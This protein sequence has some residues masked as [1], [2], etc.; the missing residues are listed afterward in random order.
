MG[1]YRGIRRLFP[2]ICCSINIYKKKTGSG[3]NDREEED[4]NFSETYGF[5][6]VYVARIF[7]ISNL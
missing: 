6:S 4:G 3:I 1:K 2:Y 5:F 7:V